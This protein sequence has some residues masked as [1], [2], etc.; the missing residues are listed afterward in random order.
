LD[1]R[2]EVVGGEV[3][4]G[5]D[6][7]GGVCVDS[8]GDVTAAREEAGRQ[9][10]AKEKKKMVFVSTCPAREN[11]ERDEESALNTVL[12]AVTDE[13]VVD[14]GVVARLEK[15]GKD[16]VIVVV[17]ADLRRVEVVSGVVDHSVKPLCKGKAGVS[18]SLKREGETKGRKRRRSGEKG[19][20]KREGQS[21]TSGAKSWPMCST[22]PAVEVIVLRQS[23]RSAAAA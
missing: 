12:D 13:R 3:V 23:S 16:R 20:R 10:E 14:E 15:L 4:C 11:R 5:R 18:E 7:G 8:D 9:R 6:Q 21:R 17:G 1:G 19:Q 22:V 2:V